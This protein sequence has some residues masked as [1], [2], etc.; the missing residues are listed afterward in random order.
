[1]YTYMIVSDQAMAKKTI[2]PSHPLAARKLHGS[3]R[4]LSGEDM[5]IIEIKNNSFLTLTKGWNKKIY[6][7]SRK[8]AM[9]F[10]FFALLI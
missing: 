7:N 5:Y 9:P 2:E 4:E 1:M 8:N 6:K 10:V 3:K